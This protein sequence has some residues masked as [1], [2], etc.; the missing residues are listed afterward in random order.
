MGSACRGKRNI[1]PELSSLLFFSFFFSS[2][3]FSPVYPRPLPWSIKG[4]AGLPITT[5]HLNSS[6]PNAPK[7]LESNSTPSDTL[8]SFTE[9]W[10]ILPLLSVY[11]PYCKHRA[12]NTS[13]IAL[14]VGTFCPNQYNFL[15]PPRS[16]S[17]PN[18]QTQ[19][20]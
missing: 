9:T 7:L 4:K 16:P 10:D 12:G 17:G 13:S 11:N 2:L 5:S 6:L 3:S 14:D 18:V 19:I 8:T 1:V 15:C 20:Y